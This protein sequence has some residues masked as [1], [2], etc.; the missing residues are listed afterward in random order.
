MYMVCSPIEVLKSIIYVGGAWMYERLA[1][2]S[3]KGERKSSCME[4][5][6]EILERIDGS[7]VGDGLQSTMMLGMLAIPFS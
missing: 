6:G 2:H 5:L 1:D 4:G 3:A 7:L